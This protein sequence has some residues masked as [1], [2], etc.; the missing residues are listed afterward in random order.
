M[1]PAYRRHFGQAS[2]TLALK[3]L[4]RSGVKLIA[5]NY[6]CRAGEID[7]IVRDGETVVFVE[8]RF[9]NNRQFGSP[10][11]SVTPTKRSKIVRCARH[12]LLHNPELAGFDCRFDI[13]GISPHSNCLGY[14][15][16]WLE[17]AFTE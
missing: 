17:S 5:R 16:E 12:F 11:E 15:I 8:V 14:K 13:V 2:E 3:Y 7:L 10:I 9:R 1:L 6:Q 4:R